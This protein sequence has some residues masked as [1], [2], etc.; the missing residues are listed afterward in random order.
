MTLGH[1]KP[2]RPTP[3]QKAQALSIY[4]ECGPAEASHQTGIASATIRSWA[5]RSGQ[6][7]LR[8]QSNV[9][10]VQAAIL[11]REQRR[12]RLADDLLAVA[13]REVAMLYQPVHTRN[14]AARSRLIESDDLP[15][16]PER[17]QMI[18]IAAIAIDKSQLLA[19]DATSRTEVDDTA[20]RREQI[21]EQLRRRFGGSG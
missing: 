15:E 8:R 6:T 11:S 1:A 12:A 9:A 2:H 19:G 18:T 16:A 21:I 10:A 14:V 4:I 13:E 7:V 17:R 5:H 3:E 20:A